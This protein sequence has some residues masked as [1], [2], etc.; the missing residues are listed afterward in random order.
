[1]TSPF[2]HDYDIDAPCNARAE[3]IRGRDPDPMIG[4]MR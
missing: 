4:H 3:V 2:G 1:L